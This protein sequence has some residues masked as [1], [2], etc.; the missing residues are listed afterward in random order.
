MPNKATIV[1]LIAVAVL[2]AAAVFLHG[3]GD[4]ILAH[5]ASAI[6]GHR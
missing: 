4:G 5:L 2:I 6:H 3:H 1:I